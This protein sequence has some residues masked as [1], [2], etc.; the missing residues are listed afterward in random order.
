MGIRKAKTKTVTNSY[1]K[2]RTE[3]WY[4]RPMIVCF[5]H[6]PDLENVQKHLKELKHYNANKSQ[7]ERVFVK[8]NL[9]DKFEDQRQKLFP[10]Y[11]AARKKGKK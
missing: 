1:D 3:T 10:Y 11:L 6:R 7:N 2:E 8:E 9:L 5:S 4:G